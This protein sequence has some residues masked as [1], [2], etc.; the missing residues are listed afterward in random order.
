[1]LLLVT[2]HLNEAL[3]KEIKKCTG[4]I[5]ILIK[6]MTVDETYTTIV[7]Q[8]HNGSVY[9]LITR[10]MKLPNKILEVNTKNS[11]W[12]SNIEQGLKSLTSNVSPIVLIKINSES[13]LQVVQEIEKIKSI[14]DFR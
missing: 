8:E 6:N 11:L 4:R 3:N 1:M 9:R 5:F 12:R 7:Q 14:T 10:V 2:E 13:H